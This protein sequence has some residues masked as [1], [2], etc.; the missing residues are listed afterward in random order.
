MSPRLDCSW[1]Q[2][3]RVMLAHDHH[4]YIRQLLPQKPRCFQP[5][6]PRH[7]YIQQDKI[8]PQLSRFSQ[9]VGTIRRFPADFAIRIR[10]EKG[11]NAT[12]HPHVIVYNE[13]PDIE[14]SL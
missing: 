8:R 9:R 7:A 5:T 11:P 3:F 6:W 1:Q 14:E 2:L 10:R 12:P 13:N 4:F